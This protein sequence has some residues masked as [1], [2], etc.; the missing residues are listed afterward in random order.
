MNPV[1]IIG[2]GAIG[3]LLAARLAQ[4]AIPVALV[5]RPY[6]VE[7]T[8]SQ[9]GI[10]LV[11]ASGQEATIAL[12]VFSSVKQA[13]LE[14]APFEWIIVAVKAYHTEEAALE[15]R[16]AGGNGLRVLTVQNGVGN[17]E[18]LAAILT[19]SPIL[20]GVLTTP[21]EVL[22]PAH[23]KISRPSF[24]FGLAAG[25]RAQTI[26]DVAWAIDKAGFTLTTYADYRALKW[27]KLLMNILANAQ[28]AI[29]GC[30]PAQIFAHPEL[31]NLELRA[32]RETLAVMKATN[33]RP[34][35]VGGYPIP[36][37]ARLV[38]KLPLGVMRPIFAHF[39]VGGRGEKMPSLYYDLHP[40][41]RTHSEIHW[42]NGA[43]MQA[44]ERLGIPTPVNTAFT[45]I[46]TAL[47]EGREPTTAWTGRPERLL[48]AVEAMPLPS[49]PTSGETP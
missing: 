5:G 8:R 11:E 1:L 17:E 7:R 42:L 31:G 18:T 33:I 20:A 14:A 43:V 28:S 45:Q 47:I 2:A 24:K 48:A 29:L 27:S 40:T 39:I 16:E 10:R 44:G 41:R 6:T 34:V 4:N 49:P 13:F 19:D 12:P 32:W 9:G 25:P 26:S 21:V 15:I 30:T 46:M 36:L 35:Q 37:A 22:Q 23:I 38:Q 3:S